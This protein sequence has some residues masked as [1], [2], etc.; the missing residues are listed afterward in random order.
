MSRP[1]YSLVIG[2]VAVVMLLSIGMV[3]QAQDPIELQLTWWGSQNRHDRTIKVV[4]MYEA[5]NPGVDIVYEFANF[6]DYWTRLNTQAAG[7][8][9]PCVMQHDY[10][11]LSEWAKRGLLAPL[12]PYFE[13]GTI[14]ISNVD[15]AYLQGGLVDGKYY[16]IS[17]GTN[18]QSMILDVDAF[19]KAGLDL[20]SPDWTWKEFEELAVALHDK[21]DIWG[22]G[23][24]TLGDDQLWTSLNLASGLQT[25]SDDGK[26]FG[27]TDDQPLVDYFNMI[28]RLQETGAIA[29]AEEITA[30][31]DT[32][33]ENSPIVTSR[34]AM[35]YQW[36][37]Q[38]VAI[39]SAAGENRHFKLWLI[40]RPEGGKSANYLKPS[41][42]FA[43]PASCEHPEEAAKF[44]NFFTNDLEANDILFA[45]RGVPIS[46][47]VRDYLKPK[48]DA[49]GAETFDFL[50]RVQVDSS[51]IF[52]PNPPGYNDIRN[53][54]YIPLFRDP[55]L[56][57][58]ISVEE[59]IAILRSE[60]EAIL[61]KN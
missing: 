32:G 61:S 28:L 47:A 24:P 9:L 22:Y 35:Q 5:E 54:V 50:E 25:F 13:D 55:V 12:D 4:E 17:L 44:I 52:P 40:P 43:I 51:P 41:M 48:L 18:S 39:F 27:Y 11:Y 3:V 46:S 49:V 6:T 14:D 36:S 15:E 58:Q 59:G 56:F 8:S 2:L 16:G 20:P 19:E 1:K 45:E 23:S 29:T 57:G 21:L 42:F 53:N 26:T 33:P 37:N 31:G 30:E 10:A 60:G 7:G 34:S 38:V